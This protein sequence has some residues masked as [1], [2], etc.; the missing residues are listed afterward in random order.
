MIDN[1]WDQEIWDGNIYVDSLKNIKSPYFS[2]LCD[3]RSVFH[4]DKG[5]DLPHSLA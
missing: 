5:L 4:L 1:N 3:C 2:E